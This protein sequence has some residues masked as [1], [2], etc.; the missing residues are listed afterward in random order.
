MW[1]LQDITRPTGMRRLAG[2]EK[3]MLQ[4]LVLDAPATSAHDGELSHSEN[5]P[6]CNQPQQAFGGRC[7]LEQLSTNYPEVENS[8]AAEK[9]SA[10]LK[11]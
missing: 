5:L 3:A 9:L 1:Q 10:S 6:V 7:F 8:L 11:V 2:L 4:R